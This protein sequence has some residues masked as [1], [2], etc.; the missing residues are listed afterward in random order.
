MLVILLLA[1]NTS[2]ECRDIGCM[3]DEYRAEFHSGSDWI[4]YYDSIFTIGSNWYIIFERDEGV[5]NPET[6]NF[7]FVDGPNKKITAFNENPKSDNGSV[8]FSGSS[9]T[10]ESFHNVF[11]INFTTTS[12]AKEILWSYE[13]EIQINKPP[14]DDLVYLWGGMS[15]FWLSIGLYVLYISNKFRELSDK[16]GVEINGDREKN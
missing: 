1:S 12:D 16:I 15:V 4:F 11:Y 13:L 7:S 8:S 10:K 5:H 3:P 6:I 14:A 2:A 9:F